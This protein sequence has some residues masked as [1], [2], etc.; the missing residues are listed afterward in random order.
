MCGLRRGER[1]SRSLSKIGG[2]ED[3]VSGENL[4]NNMI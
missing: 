3:G 1:V 4:V 2:R